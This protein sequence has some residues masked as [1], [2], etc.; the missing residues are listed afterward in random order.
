MLYI[1]STYTTESVTIGHPDKICDQISDALLDACIEQDPRSRVAIEALGGHGLVVVVGEV[2]TTAVVDM[3]TI[4]RNVYAQCG[5]AD[6]LE[7]VER[8]VHQSPD[9]AQGVDTGGAGDQGS[10]YGYATNQTPEYLP[11]GFVIARKLCS[12]LTQLREHGTISWLG[13]DGKAQVTI[14][15]GRAA[16]VLVSSQHQAAVELSE[17][18]SVL[19]QEVIQFCNFDEQCTVLINPTGQF[20]QGGFAADSGL[21]GR[22]IMVDT[23]GGLI[24][25][26]GGC[27]SGKD[28]TKVDRSGSYMARWVAK[29]VVANGLADECLVAV[30]YAI[31][32]AE[33]VMITVQSSAGASL[34]Q[35]IKQTVDF[36]PQAI[37]EQFDLLRPIYQPTARNGHFGHEVFPWEHIAEL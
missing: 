6:R 23:Y 14:E 15:N 37:I 10:M 30:A 7:V 16:T 17:V 22:K 35:H 31:G 24:A 26:G 12:H 36:R 19:E 13:P 2:T 18:R 4:V 32:Q 3:Q 21:T 28:P 29:S 1:A 25:H 34:E 33:P 8:I 20:V 11:Q 27:F 5:Y 9:I